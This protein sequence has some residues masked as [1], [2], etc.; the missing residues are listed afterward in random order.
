MAINPDG[1]WRVM[2]LL[3]YIDKHVRVHMGRCLSEPVGMHVAHGL[4]LLA[5][6]LLSVCKQ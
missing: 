2:S 3:D 5:K 4:K 6:L 1:E